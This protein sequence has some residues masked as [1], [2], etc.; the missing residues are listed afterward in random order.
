M[1]I[2]DFS[3][4]NLYNRDNYTG[5]RKVIDSTDQ[6]KYHYEVTNLGSGNN[7]WT[8]GKLSE[9]YEARIRNKRGNKRKEDEANGKDNDDDDDGY[10]DNYGDDGSGDLVLVGGGGDG[11]GFKRKKN[12]ANG[13]DAHGGDCVGGGGI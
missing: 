8:I 6:K 3:T 9:D 4:S 5:L 10:G 2:E 7:M 12:E 13:R 11:D 1:I